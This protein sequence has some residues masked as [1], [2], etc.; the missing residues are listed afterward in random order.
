MV[1]VINGNMKHKKIVKVSLFSDIKYLMVKVMLGLSNWTMTSHRF[2]PLEVCLLF[3]NCS[4]AYRK[5]IN[6]RYES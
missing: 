6:I 5:G 4:E 1:L 3:S 2:E